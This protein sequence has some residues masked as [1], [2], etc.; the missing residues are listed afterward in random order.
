MIRYLA[1]NE[2][3]KV[4]AESETIYLKDK[5][6]SSKLCD[7]DK[8]DL[9]IGYMYGDPD[10]ALISCCTTFVAIAGCGVIVYF[11]ESCKTLELYNDDAN[12]IKWTEGV[13]QGELDEPWQIG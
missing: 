9:E 12:N 10:T 7:Y 13:Y 11:I 5:S 4:Y 8:L 1:E 2:R 6:L 3:F